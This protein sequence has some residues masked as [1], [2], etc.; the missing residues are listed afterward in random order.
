[1]NVK[2]WYQLNQSEILATLQTQLTGLSAA[3]IIERQ[4][5]HNNVL[6][7]AENSKPWLIFLRQ[8]TDTMV[9][10]LLAATVISGAIGAMADAVTILAIVIINALLGFVQEYRAERSL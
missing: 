3:Q 4:R 1:M 7:A 2:P 9:L 5:I 8:F 6:D 10:V